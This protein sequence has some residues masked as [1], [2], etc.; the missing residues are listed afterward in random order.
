MNHTVI[1]AITRLGAISGA[2]SCEHSIRPDLANLNHSDLPVV[3]LALMGHGFCRV[4]DIFDYLDGHDSPFDLDDLTEVLFAHE[5]AD[6]ARHL[7]RRAD[8]GS[9]YPLI[10][11][12]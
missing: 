6:P 2:L 5:G 8:H 10:S 11:V 1:H 9:Y 3:I 12:G 4:T 7:W